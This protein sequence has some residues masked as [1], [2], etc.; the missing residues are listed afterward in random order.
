MCFCWTCSLLG[1]KRFV[2]VGRGVTEVLRE[3]GH[4]AELGAGPLHN[5]SLLMVVTLRQAFLCDAPRS[6]ITTTQNALLI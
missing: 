6:P 1:A 3:I 5:F 4:K 2:G